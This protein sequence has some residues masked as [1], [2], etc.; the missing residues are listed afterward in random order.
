MRLLVLIANFAIWILVLVVILGCAT[1][2]VYTN[3]G[4]GQAGNYSD[5]DTDIDSE[6]GHDLGISVKATKELKVGK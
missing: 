3:S 2:K 4:E 6:I 5:T 1:T